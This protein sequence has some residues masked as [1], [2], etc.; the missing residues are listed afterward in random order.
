MNVDT[1]VIERAV[2]G[3]PRALD[4]VVRELLPY[5]GRICGAIA[6]GAGDDAMQEAMM[7]IIKNI[8]TLREPAALHGW[9][10]RIAVREAV[11]T[12]HG[13]RAIPT[14]PEVMKTIAAISDDLQAVEVVEILDSLSPDQRAVLVLRHIDGLNEDEMAEALG[15]KVGTIKSRLHRARG[16][17]ATKWTR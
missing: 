15:V 6:L 9:A 5:I 14:D 13:G 8:H 1:V 16:S 10:R 3:D 17:F 7:S 4:S 2:R 11:R 12:A